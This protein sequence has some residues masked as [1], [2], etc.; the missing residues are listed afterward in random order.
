[1]SQNLRKIASLDKRVKAV[2]RLSGLLV[3][4]TGGEAF[5]INV[6]QIRA[7]LDYIRRHITEMGSLS[8][9]N[10]KIWRAKLGGDDIDSSVRPLARSQTKSLFRA[11][12][13]TIAAANDVTVSEDSNE[14]MIDKKAIAEALAF[15][16]GAE[17]DPVPDPY[18]DVSDAAAPTP[19]VNMVLYGPPGTGKTFRSAVEAVRLCD[20]LAETADILQPPQRHDLMKRYR[21]LRESRQIE[22]VTF[23][24]SYAYEDF[25]EGLRPVTEEGAAGFRLR[26]S[27]GVFRRLAEQAEKEPHKSFVLIIDEINRGNLSKIFGELIT[28]IEPDK[29]LGA[30]HEL[31]VTLPYS[32]KTFGVPANLHIIG[33]MNT[34]DRSIALLDMALRRRFDFKELLPDPALLGTVDGVNLTAVLRNLNDRI[35]YLFDRDHQI[36]HAYL[37]SCKNRQDVDSAFRRKIIPLLVEY[38]YEDWEKVRN[39]LAENADAGRFINRK[40][41]QVPGVE[42]YGFASS[43]RWRYEVLETFHPDAYRHLE[44]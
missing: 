21:Q 5:F 36:G 11:L 30:A 41:L 10:E 14:I 37:L 25:V 9:Y 24:Q 31:K 15:L 17:D 22:F 38:F 28:L 23:H 6:A 1:M 26:P 18:G 12:S 7:A 27:K 29:R 33:T 43:E 35:E 4:N 2:E 42:S 40:K 32:G 34:A 39:A 20:N 3:S 16:D 13:R 44:G 8:P 19:P